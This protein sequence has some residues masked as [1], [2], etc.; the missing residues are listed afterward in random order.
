M[1][2]LTK[3]TKKTFTNFHFFQKNTYLSMVYIITCMKNIATSKIYALT[4][5]LIFTVSFS[6]ALQIQKERNLNKI[7][8]KGLRQG[9]WIILGKDR[10]EKGFP[11]DGKIAEGTFVDDKKNGLWTMY[12]KDGLTPEIKGEFVNNRP[13]GKFKKFYPNGVLKEVGTFEQLQYKDSLFRFNEKGTKTY[14]A[15]F[16][17]DGDE[18]GEVKYYYDNQQLEFVYQVKNGVPSGEATRYWPNGEVKEKIIYHANGTLMY[19]S[20]I[21]SQ[22]NENVLL[23]K[24]INE[25]K[26]APFLPNKL[27]NQFNGDKYN[28]VY[29][30][31]NELWMEGIFKNRQLWNGRLY[32]YDANGL[33]QKIEVYKLG[34]YHSDG[35]L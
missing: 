35:Q 12:Y 17:Q 32:I 30:E 14:E 22:Q 6:F 20:G 2:Y 15:Y 16:D 1:N 18:Q 11:L 3:I 26:D 4:V 21:L 9:K 19:S 24:Q 27:E 23:K 29:N 34:K 31:N 13:H 10:P 5:F 28:K 7:D 25:S 8:R 33:L